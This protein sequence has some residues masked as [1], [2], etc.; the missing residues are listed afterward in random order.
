MKVISIRDLE[1]CG[2][3]YGKWVK[4]IFLV[5][6]ISAAVRI[7]IYTS[8]LLEW[9]SSSTSQ[10]RCFSGMGFILR[11]NGV[12]HNLLPRHRWNL[13]FTNYEIIVYLLIGEEFYLCG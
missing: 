5:L 9:N 12:F 4:G 2:Y 11:D 13:L 3:C 10:K 6:V 8:R 7:H 1:V